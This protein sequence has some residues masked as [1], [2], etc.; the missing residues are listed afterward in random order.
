M[1]S[2]G[3]DVQCLISMIPSNEESWMF[4]YQNIHLIDLVSEALE[5][6]LVKGHTE[7]VKEEEVE[8]LKSTIE[9]IEVEGI[10]S[11]AISSHYQKSRID[12]ICRQLGFKSLTPLWHKD[13]LEILCEV[14]NI[15]LDV[16]ITGAYAYGFSE[17][18]LGRRIDERT[19]DELIELGKK[20]GI[21][22]VGDGGEYE[23]LVLDAPFFK[24][25]IEIVAA[26]RIWEEQR[27][28]YSVT[29]A[30]LREK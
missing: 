18:W 8:D 20:H 7:G 28:C 3:H 23:T 6:P 13:E 11:G 4:H 30:E 14:L 22:L 25:R 29:A 24:K 27:G 21:S 15:Q 10:V 9:Q 26:K 5:I 16:I 1:L 17:E 2:E 12:R 19:V